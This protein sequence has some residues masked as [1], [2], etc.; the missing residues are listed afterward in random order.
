M[1]VT[2]QTVTLNESGDGSLLFTWQ[3]DV[4]GDGEQW[5]ALEDTGRI[6]LKSWQVD[7][8]VELGSLD[9]MQQMVD[10]VRQWFQDHKKIPID[11]YTRIWVQGGPNAL[12]A[13][14]LITPTIAAVSP[15]PV[16]PNDPVV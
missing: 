15:D 9:V 8:A 3:A 4:Q 16:A 14:V 2:V 13:Q 6:F 7:K 10:V 5:A 12:S 1:T 11:S